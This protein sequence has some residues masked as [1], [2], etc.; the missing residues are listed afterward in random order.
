MPDVAH[1]ASSSEQRSIPID[2]TVLAI[3]VDRADARWLQVLRSDAPAQTQ[4]LRLDSRSRLSVADLETVRDACNSRVVVVFGPSE[5]SLGDLARDIQPLTLVD[6]QEL[7]ALLVPGPSADPIA[8]AQRLSVQLDIDPRRRIDVTGVYTLYLALVDQMLRLD[9][10]VLERVNQL[11]ALLAWPLRP[12][13]LEAERAVR[14]N[15]STPLQERT[16]LSVSS[17]ATLLRPVPEP[18]P[19]SA[20]H[21]PV[22]LE[23]ARRAL[24]HGGAMAG[25]IDVFEDRP[26]QVEMLEAVVETFNESGQTIIE[27]G[28]GTGKSFAYLIPAVMFAH[29]NNRHVVVSTNTI[30]LQDQL[31]QRDLPRVIHAL[32]ADVRTAIVKGRS[33]YLCLRR[34]SQLLYADTLTEAERTLLIKTLIWL[35]RTETGD[36]SEL[37]LTAEELQAWQRV[38]A[39]AEA[40]TPTRCQ[41]H[42]AGVC[43]VARARKLAEAS[44]IVIINH[45][46]LLSDALNQAHVLPDYHHL[47]VDEAHHLEDEATSQLS[48]SITGREVK[49]HLDLLV[50]TPNG[51]GLLRQVFEILRRAGSSLVATYG[52]SEQAVRRCREGAEALLATLDVFLDQHG[53]RG[54]GGLLSTRITSASRAQPAWSHV[55]IAWDGFGRTLL[56]LGRQIS[57][58]L[59]A[60]EIYV[61]T[62]EEAS[63]IAAQLATEGAFWEMTRTQLQRAIGEEGAD[64][65]T[66]LTQNRADDVTINLAPLEVGDA[67]NHRV[68]QSKE[69]VILTS[70]TLSTADSFTYVTS[71]LGLEDTRSLKVDSPFDYANAA[72]VV[73]P[74]DMPEPND[75]RYQ[76]GVDWSVEEIVTAVRGRTLVLFT[77]YSQLR[78]THRGVQSALQRKGIQVLAQGI[79]SGSRDQLLEAFRTRQ[80]AV[81]LGT[82][83]FWE[84]VD[85]VGETLSC[86]IMTRL[87]FSVPTD[88]VFQARSELFENPFGS[89][90]VPQAI[91]RFRQGFGR[92]IRSQHDRGAMVVLDRR[93]LSKSYGSRFLKSLPNAVLVTPQLTTVPGQLATWLSAPPE[94]APTPATA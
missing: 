35:P 87:P 90:A 10:G 23:D 39:I 19:A 63:E 5:Q 15:W 18:L 94:T 13:M 93:T 73:I 7:A 64:P 77:S 16:P 30:N 48:W 33:N 43:F 36:Y 50:D 72:M 17:I 45:A 62:R 75:P 8:I 9:L 60:T 56:H 69:C 26:T 53:Q 2:F 20:K 1:E 3:R 76:R 32:H 41:Y 65:V 82:A 92:L 55:E 40:C 28:T 34:W 74:A 70:A 22:S 37:S 88:P 27:A 67:L 91:L 59:G 80:P 25:E 52:D 78:A 66:W 83:S 12:L 46:L 89:Y 57:Q 31:F 71:R 21:R 29:A 11:S 81:L 4:T 51:P 86:V 24:S 49:R 58:A 79:D 14:R 68:F 42:R 38:N 6:V 47:I 44:H 84:G 85:V 54:D 61:G